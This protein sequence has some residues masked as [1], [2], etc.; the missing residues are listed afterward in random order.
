LY[1]SPI[2]ETADFKTKKAEGRRQ[3]PKTIDYPIDMPLILLLPNNILF[4]F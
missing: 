1:Q 4:L 3:K 2:K